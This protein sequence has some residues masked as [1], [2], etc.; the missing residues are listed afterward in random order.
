MVNFT[1][2]STLL[3]RLNLKFEKLDS[4]NDITK[5]LFDLVYEKSLYKINVDN[6]LLMLQEKGGISAE[7]ARKANYSAIQQFGGTE[8]LAYVES[9]IDQYVQEVFLKIPENKAEDEIYVLYLLNNADVEEEN[10]SSIISGQYIEVSDLAKVEDF[11][12]QQ[13]VVAESAMVANWDNVFSYYDGALAEREEGDEDISFDEILIGYLNIEE[14]YL[15]LAEQKISDAAPRE[16]DYF[17]SFS[18]ELMMSNQLDDEAYFAL[19]GAH[20]YNFDSEDLRVLDEKKIA[21]SVEN[22]RVDL[23]KEMY[24]QLKEHFPGL[25][26]QLVEQKQNFLA[27]QIDELAIDIADSALLLSSS[28]LSQENKLLVYGRL[29]VDDIIG[30]PAVSRPACHLLSAT[31]EVEVSFAV[32]QSMFAHSNSYE[33]RINLLNAQFSRLSPDQIIGLVESLGGDYPE[34]FMKRHKPKFARTGFHEELFS[35][36]EKRR[37]IKSYEPY[38]KDESRWRVHAIY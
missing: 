37:M 21:W 18:V 20:Y 23:N 32:M 12:L 26:V 5:N 3:E 25:Q 36:L 17:S 11:D 28:V 2:I 1:G 7:E 8:M 6:V 29:T 4:T 35:K 14:N 19:M 24:D 27:E 34:I 16:N 9:K 13:Q 38:D 33:D 31:P 10:K 22:H 15:K 30:N